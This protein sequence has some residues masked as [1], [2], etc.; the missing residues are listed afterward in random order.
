M[1]T[2]K[3]RNKLFEDVYNGLTSVFNLPYSL[4]KDFYTVLSKGL[5]SGFG[6]TTFESPARELIKHLDENIYIFSG[7]KTY[8]EIFNLQSK[9]FD[10][11][12]F[13]RP[14]TEFKKDANVIHTAYSEEWLQAEYQTTTAQARSAGKWVEFEDEK[15]L[16]PY[17]RYKTVGDGRVRETHAKLH[18]ITKKVTDPFWNDF[19]PANGFRCRC[20]LVQVTAEE[21]E[22]TKLT[23]KQQKELKEELDPLFRMNPAKD[24]IIFKKGHPYMN[25]L[26]L[27]PRN[28]KVFMVQRENN[29]GFEKPLTKGID[30]D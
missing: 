10:K 29:F 9:I 22:P 26:N 13:K 21:V 18:N 12:G 30:Y 6:A 20:I 11:E 7:A 24:K 27:P 19:T 4:F 25:A 15:D 17:L 3:E 8:K 28:R 23:K 16:F 2:T 1:L 14:F 5:V